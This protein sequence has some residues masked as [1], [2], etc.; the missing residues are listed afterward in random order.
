MNL[1]YINK[2]IKN[3]NKFIKSLLKLSLLHKIFIIFL[4]LLFAC[5]F[6]N[7]YNYQYIEN[8]NNEEKFI[9]KYDNDIYDNHYAKHYDNIFLNKKRNNFEFENIKPYI[10]D[11]NAKILDIGTGTGYTTHLFNKNNIDS[12]G[13]DKSSDMINAAKKKYPNSK[14]EIG[15]ILN[16]KKFDFNEFSHITCLGKTIYEI[17]DKKTFFENCKPLL[18]ENGYLILHLLDRD[19]FKPYVQEI[20]KNVLYNPEKYN[21]NIDQLLVK[22]DKN[23][24]YI[25]NYK[26]KE[27][28]STNKLGNDVTPYITYYEKFENFSNNNVRK[29]EINLYIPEISK[30]L[31]LAKVKGFKLIDKIE[32]DSVGYLNEFL[33]IFKKQ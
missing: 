12:V 9:Q 25:S 32:M 19:K 4:I 10:K 28:E 26:K 22:F 6:N 24:E 13:I 17:K 31:E 29:N 21:K 7:N 30:I 11:N 14:Y 8:F 2:N 18:E 20:D 1:E 16:T 23:N 27:D 5:I 3:I 33:Y 15:D